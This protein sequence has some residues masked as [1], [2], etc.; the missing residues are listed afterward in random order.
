MV[1]VS[2]DALQQQL[3]PEQRVKVGAEKLEDYC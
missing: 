3:G 2:V 1:V